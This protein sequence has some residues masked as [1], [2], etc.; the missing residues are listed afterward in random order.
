MTE[1]FWFVQFLAVAVLG[2]TFGRPG[3]LG[4]LVGTALSFIVL[5]L[6]G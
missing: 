5:S 6:W 3:V 1:V 2:L 4:S